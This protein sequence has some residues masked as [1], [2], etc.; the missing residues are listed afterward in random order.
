MNE[1]PKYVWTLPKIARLLLETNC[2]RDDRVG[3]MYQF[4]GILIPCQWEDR[5]LMK[6]ALT[7]ALELL[8][9]R[10]KNEV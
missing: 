5:E 6:T 1:P 3:G 2:M 7:C 9:K 4:R 10:E 8:A